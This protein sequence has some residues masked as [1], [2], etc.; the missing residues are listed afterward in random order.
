MT[1]PHLLHISKISFESFIENFDFLRSHESSNASICDIDFVYTIFSLIFP[2][3]RMF[4]GSKE[5]KSN[6]IDISENESFTNY[7][8][9]VFNGKN[10]IEKSALTSPLIKDFMTTIYFDNQV[11]NDPVENAFTEA[12]LID[13][14]APIFKLFDRFEIQLDKDQIQNVNEFLEKIKSPKIQGILKL[15]KIEV[16]IN[17]IMKYLKI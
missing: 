3:V 9:I 14:T 4:V 7:C 6:F 1:I 17:V 8:E 10:G 13:S 16:L 15:E 11:L 12:E 2:Y 5:D